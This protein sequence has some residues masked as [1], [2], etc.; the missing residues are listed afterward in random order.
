M[1]GR[2]S[3]PPSSTA[4]PRIARIE[5]LGR[6]FDLGLRAERGFATCVILAL[7]L[8]GSAVARAALI[9]TDLLAFN[10]QVRMMVNNSI[11]ATYDLDIPKPPEPVPE[12]PKDEPPPPPPE[13]VKEVAPVK[14]EKTEAPSPAPQPAQAAAVLTKAP[15]PNEPVDLTGGFVNGTGTTYAGGVTSA[16]GTGGPTYNTHATVNGAPGGTGTAPG[17]AVDHSRPLTRTDET[18]CR[19]FPPESDRDTA[20]VSVKVSVNADGTLASAQVVQDPGQGFAREARVCV[21]K[22]RFLPQLDRDGHPMPSSK[23]Y[24]VHFER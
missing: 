13:P 7:L 15:D 18:E 14:A 20:V 9:S 5:P 16:K 23:V 11:V 24:N 8:H 21:A 10:Q 2:P 4:L 22:F 19:N 17:P 1:A 12:P 3:Q 6:V